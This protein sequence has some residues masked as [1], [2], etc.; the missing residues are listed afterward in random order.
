MARMNSNRSERERLDLE[1]ERIEE[2]G[3]PQT[4]AVTGAGWTPA[5]MLALQRAGAGNHAISL[6]LLAGNQGV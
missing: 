5:N 6:A 1:P 3:P 2:P 4:T